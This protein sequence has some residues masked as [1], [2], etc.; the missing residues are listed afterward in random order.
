MERLDFETL[1]RET[2]AGMREIA[3]SAN[4][5]IGPGVVEAAEIFVNMRRS[6]ILAT[7]KRGELTLEGWQQHVRHVGDRII[8]TLRKRK[9]LAIHRPQQLVKVA[10]PIIEGYPY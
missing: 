9:R 7:W 3:R 1:K 2:K 10:R 4:I 8:K 6:A 5:S